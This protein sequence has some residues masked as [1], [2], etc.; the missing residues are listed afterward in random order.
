MTS[1]A[2]YINACVYMWVPELACPAVRRLESAHAELS[3]RRT[4]CAMIYPKDFDYCKDTT[5]QA[6]TK[7]LQRR[8]V[9]SKEALQMFVPDRKTSLPQSIPSPT[10]SSVPVNLLRRR[11]QHT[12]FK[13]NRSSFGSMS[14]Q[15]K[16]SAPTETTPTGGDHAPKEKTLWHHYCVRSSVPGF[17]Y[18]VDPAVRL[19][20]R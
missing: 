9:W 15:I 3:G 7:Q 20:Q 4:G 10:T 14:S 12:R 5:S 13:M 19:P 6:A 8:C 1:L 16:V 11:R 18:L 2:K 17:R